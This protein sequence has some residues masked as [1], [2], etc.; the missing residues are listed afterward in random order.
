MF[1][2]SSRWFSFRNAVAITVCVSLLPIAVGWSTTRYARGQ[3]VEQ[4]AGKPR[5]G[6]PEGSWPNLE[7]VQREG[8]AAREREGAQRTGPPPIPSTVRSPKVP[9][10]P[11]NGRRVGDHIVRTHARKKVSLPPLLDDQ[12]IQKL[13]YLG[14]GT[15]SRW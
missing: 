15:R 9:L 8:E 3:S 6:R 5:P 11:W 2:H 10:Q 14:V 12:F 4:R 13:F 7:E 1:P